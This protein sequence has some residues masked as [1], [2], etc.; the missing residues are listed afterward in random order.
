M[1]LVIQNLP[2]IPMH[3]TPEIFYSKARIHSWWDR[4]FNN[5]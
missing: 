4:G 1:I 2:A 5:S 3:W